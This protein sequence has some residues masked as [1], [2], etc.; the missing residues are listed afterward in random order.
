MM[1]VDQ[2]EDALQIYQSALMELD[3]S[4]AL[5]PLV[6]VAVAQTQTMIGNYDKAA[7]EYEKIRGIEGFQDIG[8]LGLARISEEQGDKEKA[9]EIYE[10][11]LTTLMNV[12]QLSQKSLVEEKIARLKALL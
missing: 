3:E 8:Y 7:V 6:S 2:K 12:T 10:E 9:L 4:S 11:Y 1:K 5:Y